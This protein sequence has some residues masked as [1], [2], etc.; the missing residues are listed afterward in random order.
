[1]CRHSTD[2]NVWFD[3]TWTWNID[4]MHYFT[5]W[6]RMHRTLRYKTRLA[7]K[8]FLPLYTCTS[9]LGQFS[10][11]H[12]WIVFTV[13]SICILYLH[14]FSFMWYNGHLY[15]LILF[16]FFPN[17]MCFIYSLIKYRNKMLMELGFQSWIERE[18]GCYRKRYESW[19]PKEFIDLLVKNR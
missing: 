9:S 10:A 5:S 1:M 11:I 12:Q 17:V 3:T 18:H 8:S 2:P 14:Y 16:F 4:T 19:T 7:D 6:W 13:F 15:S